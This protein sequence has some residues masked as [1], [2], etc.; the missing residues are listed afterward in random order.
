M[1]SME[2]EKD[3]ILVNSVSIEKRLFEDIKLNTKWDESI[4]SRKTVSYGIPYNYSGITYSRS[5]IPNYLDEL[6]NLVLHHVGFLP[7]NC[8]INYY[9]NGFS[10]MGFH[11]DQ[12]DRLIDGTGIAIFSLGSSRIIRFRSKVNIER[13]IDIILNGGSLFYMS[14]NVQNNWMHAILPD[15]ENIQSERISITFRMLTECI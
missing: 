6:R 5:A 3:I 1:H 7:N 4:R 10:K 13:K 11:S 14:Q 8:L 12:I 2:L 15:K 9:L